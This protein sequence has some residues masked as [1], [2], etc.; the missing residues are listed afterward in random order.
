[1]ASNSGFLCLSFWS[2]KV[3]KL[4]HHV[5]LSWSFQRL[6]CSGVITYSEANPHSLTSKYLLNHKTP[7]LF[8]LLSPWH[9]HLFTWKTTTNAS[10]SNSI[11]ITVLIQNPTHTHLHVTFPHTLSSLACKIVTHPTVGLTSCVNNPSEKFPDSP[12]QTRAVSNKLNRYVYLLQQLL[13]FNY[14]SYFPNS[15]E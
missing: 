2:D 4:Q 5:Q 14:F 15:K 7:I 11:Q 12:K 8:L 3:T 9:R 6:T 1:M 13:S 10:A